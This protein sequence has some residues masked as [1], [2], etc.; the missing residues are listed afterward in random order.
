MPFIGNQPSVERLQEHKVYSGDGTRRAFGVQYEDNAVLVFMNGIKLKE[1]EDYLIDP[2]GN[3]IEFVQPP[4]VGD[5]V[6]LYGTNGVTDLARSSYSRETFTAGQG[7][8]LFQLNMSLTGGE[9][10]NVYLNGLRISETDFDIDYINKT[11][12]VSEREAD[13]VL[14]IEIIAHGFRSSAHNSKSEKA[15][16]PMFSTPNKINSDLYINE[17]ENA[18]VVGPV[19]LDGVITLKGT[20]TIV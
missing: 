4:E 20:L 1:T 10:I 16:H 2:N 3:F 8:T 19:T 9:R 13:D 7:Q 5:T 17:D 14:V 11:V 18:M 15:F 6:D 12:T